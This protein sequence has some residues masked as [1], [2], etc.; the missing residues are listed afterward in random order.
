MPN[1][2]QFRS[3]LGKAPAKSSETLQGAETA[4]PRI[5]ASASEHS[6]PEP[7]R[8]KR[9]QAIRDNLE[10]LMNQVE[11]ARRDA[12]QM[13]EEMSA[14]EIDAG[15]A[16]SLRHENDA[17]R[18]QLDDAARE[19]M[20]EAAKAQN[21]SREIN[22]LKEE[23]SRIRADYE[24]SQREASANKLDAERIEDRLRAATASLNETKRE[25]E[26][27]REAKEKAEVDAACLRANLA[28]RDRAQSNLLQQE[29]ELRMQAA[30]LQT[31]YDEVTEALARKERSV[32]EKISQVES[33]KDRIADLEAD[34][35]AAREEL[36]VLGNKYSDLKVS[37]E[38]RIYSLNDGLNQER[39]SHQMTRKLL[40]EARDS[41]ELLSD[42][43]A[44]LKAQGLN[45]TQDQQ[46]AQRELASARTQLREYGD[47]LKEAHFRLAA[48]EGDI[49]RLENALDDAK[50]D[51][52]SLRREASK[53][54]QLLRENT[55]LHEK[56]ASLQERLDR[57]RGSSMAD[58]VPVMLSSAKRSTRTASAT[59]KS[60]DE[61][62]TSGA[63]N[64]ARIVR[65]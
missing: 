28:E 15:M 40:E 26:M 55:D 57:Y 46:K 7:S 29:T 12:D 32:L 20:A 56:V 52:I 14:L 45:S 1:A 34:N 11:H 30:K 16:K 25:L 8:A 48:A 33:Q 10:M 65:R 19:I 36:R 47:K 37:Q 39:E 27:Q 58:D 22:R 2:F 13:M 62:V 49:Q 24:K 43:V 9:S 63:Q 51:A 59:A 50:K 23:V 42:E 44:T 60:D 17:L 61:R 31:Q 35:E 4:A 6:P 5:S 64:V 3:L 38:S 18:D 53:S 21:A 54:D 41:N